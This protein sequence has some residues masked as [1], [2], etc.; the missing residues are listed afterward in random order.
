MPNGGAGWQGPLL[1]TSPLDRLRAVARSMMAPSA[2][3]AFLLLS[4]RRYGILLLGTQWS[5][6]A[7][8]IIPPYP[9]LKSEDP[10]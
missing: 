1:I 7:A 10:P 2:P 3:S 6:E 4:Q 5:C 9:D 8:A